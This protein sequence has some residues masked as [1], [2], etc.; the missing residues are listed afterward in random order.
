MRQP[1]AISPPWPCTIAIGWAFKGI[2]DYA[3]QLFQRRL[4]LLAEDQRDRI[5]TDAQAGVPNTF[6]G[7]SL[8][9]AT[10]MPAAGGGEALEQMA[11]GAP[12]FGPVAA[13]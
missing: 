8:Q 12:G 1:R 10:T 7:N 9:A 3:Q 6:D 5:R 2:G 11:P 4:A 13:G